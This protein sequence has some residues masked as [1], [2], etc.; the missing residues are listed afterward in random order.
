METG[1]AMRQRGER[2]AA[3]TNAAGIP[4]YLKAAYKAELESLHKR[5]AFLPTLDELKA[6]FRERVSGKSHSE[7]PVTILLAI[8][9]HAALMAAAGTAL[10]G[11]SPATFLILRGCVETSPYAYLVARDA[12]DGDVWLNRSQDPKTAKEKFKANR[13]IQKLT[14]HDANLAIHVKETYDSSS[15]GTRT[16][17]QFS[18]TFGFRQQAPPTIITQSH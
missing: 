13:A 18:T 9:A 6:L 5:K 14:P 11:Q 17:G 8:N 7:H 15:A 1:N 16:Q 2:P 12:A 3:D 4:S 10:R